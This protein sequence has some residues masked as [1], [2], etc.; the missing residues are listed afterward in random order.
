MVDMSCASVCITSMICFFFEK[1]C[2]RIK[3]SDS[4]IHAFT[5]REACRGIGTWFLCHGRS[6][7]CNCK[8][9]SVPA[10]CSHVLEMILLMLC[11]CY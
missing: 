1:T 9:K 2:R 3:S 8:V 7:P 4:D 6:Y 10:P 11:V 5:K